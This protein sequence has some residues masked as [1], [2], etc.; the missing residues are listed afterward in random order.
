MKF[1]H[2]RSRFLLLALACCV[3]ATNVTVFAA[4]EDKPR[5]AFDSD[6]LAQLDAEVRQERSRIPNHKQRASRLLKEAQDRRGQNR[7]HWSYFEAQAVDAFEEAGDIEAAKSVLRQI[8]ARAEYPGQRSRACLKLGRLSERERPADALAAYTNGEQLLANSLSDNENLRVY[9]ELVLQR[10]T[11]ES[12]LGKKQQAIESRRTILEQ[13]LAQR[14]DAEHCVKLHV[15]SARDYF[16][17]DNPSL[18]REL[19]KQGLQMQPEWG[20]HNGKRAK[21]RI[22][23]ACGGYV[24]FERRSTDR[25]M[26]REI[27][28]E[29]ASSND[30]LCMYAYRHLRHSSFKQDRNEILADC[31]DAEAVFSRNQAHWQ[32]SLSPEKYKQACEDYAEVVVHYALLLEEDRSYQDAA[33][34]C[35][36]HLAQVPTTPQVQLLTEIRERCMMRAMQHR[37]NK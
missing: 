34:V 6:D 32:T 35:T 5:Y 8:S 30:P 23:A 33:M 12:M 1:A 10:A 16:D 19:V 25:V 2:N 20:L 18:A 9:T 22:E 7:R 11:L 37:N 4:S 15:D 24:S 13:G 28:H 17:T 29:L 31:R 14:L 3:H 26:L 27:A 21:L 36:T